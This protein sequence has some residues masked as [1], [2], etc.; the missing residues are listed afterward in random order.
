MEVW[1]KEMTHIEDMLLVQA[2]L[3]GFRAFYEP[4]CWAGARPQAVTARHCCTAGLLQREAVGDRE[5]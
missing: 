5:R 4:G 3:A 1:D 2:S